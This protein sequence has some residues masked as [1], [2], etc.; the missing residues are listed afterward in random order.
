MNS[1]RCTLALLTGFSIF[2]VSASGDECPANLPLDQLGAGTTIS[3]KS[4]IELDPKTREVLK[5]QSASG[6]NVF[7]IGGT[8]YDDVD[9]RGLVQT[10]V[11]MTFQEQS[12][13]N[14]ARFKAG[15][16]DSFSCTLE[17][18]PRNPPQSSPSWGGHYALLLTQPCPVAVIDLN[19]P[20]VDFKHELLNLGDLRSNLGAQFQINAQCPA[21]HTAKSPQINQRVGEKSNQ[22]LGTPTGTEP[23][24]KPAIQPTPRNASDIR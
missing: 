16:I 4:P 6:Y 3:L 11:E 13:P 5:D 23:T 18:N 14:V 1:T 15:K 9:L 10:S 24:G 2:T 19:K 20:F 17:L 21:I 8:H 12:A 7:W 22:Q